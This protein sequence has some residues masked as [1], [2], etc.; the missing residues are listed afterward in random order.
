MKTARE[1]KFW[2]KRRAKHP[3]TGLAKYGVCGGDLAPIGQDDLACS[4]AHHMGTCANRKR[5][6]RPLLEGLILDTLKDNLMAPD[7]VK[8]FSRDF[9]AEVNRRRRDVELAAGQKKELADVS[10]KLEGLIEGIAEGLRGAGLQLKLDEL[11]ARKL[12]LT[13]DVVASPISEPRLSSQFRRYLSE[14]G[15]EPTGGLARSCHT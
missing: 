7:L 15:R 5:L 11:E 9:H 3:L 2:L 6:R 14:E 1:K 12:V 10:R 13:N 4:A 8:K